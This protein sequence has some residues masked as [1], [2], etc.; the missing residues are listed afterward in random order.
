MPADSTSVVSH[1]HAFTITDSEVYLYDTDVARAR[2][3]ASRYRA[4]VVTD[5]SECLSKP[6]DIVVI[7]SPTNSHLYYLSQ[8][9]SL[10][11]AQ[12]LLCEKPISC[13]LHE[14]N[15]L[16]S[17]YLAANKRVFVN[18]SRRFSVPLKRAKEFVDL[19]HIRQSLVSVT[20]HYQR[21]FINNATHALDFLSYLFDEVIIPENATIDQCVFD[22]FDADPTLSFT[23]NHGEY[24]LNVIGLPNVTYSFFEISIFTKS[25]VLQFRDGC[26][27]FTISKAKLVNRA[28]TSSPYFLPSTVLKSDNCMSSC[29]LDTAN[30]L[31]RA[32]SDASINDNF[33]ISLALNK[34]ALN[35]IS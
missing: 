26:N 24:S 4:K 20:I 33:L 31:L 8:V 7:A 29:A 25:H 16:E 22:E 32:S 5:I 14:L 6:L 13:S 19:H 21:G 15:E 3:A 12:V 9:L 1:A 17:M 28:S 18:Y 34:A 30:H 27:S 23:S 2:E 10:S 35:L 11:S